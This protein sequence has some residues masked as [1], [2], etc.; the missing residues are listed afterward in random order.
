MTLRT[1]AKSRLIKPGVVIKSVIPCT[2]AS[3]TWSALLKASSAV[4]LRSEI[5]KRRSFGITINVSTS[6]RNSAIPS[7]A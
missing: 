4:M 2:P 1:S 6:A 7:S 5:D 3:R